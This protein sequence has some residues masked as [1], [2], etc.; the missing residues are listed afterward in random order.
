MSNRTLL[1]HTSR[2][3]RER[4]SAATDIAALVASLSK[5]CIGFWDARTV[6]PAGSYASWPGRAGDLALTGTFTINASGQVVASTALQTTTTAALDLSTGTK[7]LVLGYLAQK[8]SGSGF[9]FWAGIAGTSGNQGQY[10]D[11]AVQKGA[12]GGA[13]GAGNNAFYEGTVGAWAGQRSSNNKLIVGALSTNATPNTTVQY[14][15]GLPVTVA[16][17]STTNNSGNNRVQLGGSSILGNLPYTGRWAAAFTGALT[18]ADLAKINVWSQAH[19]ATTND[20]G[21]FVLFDGDSRTLGIPSSVTDMSTNFP[22]VAMG[23][24]RLLTYGDWNLGQGGQTA[25]NMATR[26]NTVPHVVLTA[27]VSAKK[28][29]VLHAG[30]N[31]FA[32]GQTAAQIYANLKLCWAAAKADGAKV[33]ACTEVS[34]GTAGW[35]AGAKNTLNGLITGTPGLYDALADFG[36]NATVGADGQAQTAA[37]Q[38]DHVHPTSASYAIM[39]GLVATAVASL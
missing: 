21:A 1:L 9:G 17:F 15:P 16:A 28:I 26:F 24:S 10:F 14:Y 19:H 27:S 8:W 7:T 23:D 32:G 20:P 30:I 2:S 22:T 34:A 12:E 3:A 6:G 39:G 33:V 37:F 11:R 35:D 18:S 4:N 38:S 5:S 13:S 29:Y 31:D 25:A 36:A